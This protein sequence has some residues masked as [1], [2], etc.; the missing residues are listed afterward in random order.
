[1]NASE[2]YVISLS[3]D[4]YSLATGKCHRY[5]V[6]WQANSDLTV[7]GSIPRC[8]MSMIGEEKL[9]LLIQQLQ[10]IG[11]AVG[12]DLCRPVSPARSHDLDGG[13]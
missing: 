6:Q 13:E 8:P 9:R 4:F 5:F 1:M 3:A 7:S 2:T 11:R 12:S 10:T